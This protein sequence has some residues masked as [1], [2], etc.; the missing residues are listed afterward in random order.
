M[1][2]GRER[3]TRTYFTFWPTEEPAED[4]GVV[5]VVSVR[6]VRTV[7]SFDSRSQ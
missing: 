6:C 2:E 7:G 4:P 1:R 3:E 5:F